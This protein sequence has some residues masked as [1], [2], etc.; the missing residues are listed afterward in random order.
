MASAAR[1]ISRRLMFLAFC[2]CFVAL[3]AAYIG[4]A[5]VESTRMSDAA[6]ETA[7]D[8]APRGDAPAIAP[9]PKDGVRLPSTSA[10]GAAPI[11]VAG[12]PLPSAPAAADRPVVENPAVPG[13]RSGLLFTSAAYDRT[14]GHLAVESAG[15][16][17]TSRQVAALRC[18]RVHF[19]GGAGICLA[20]ERGFFTTYAA[21]TF[22]SDFKI[23]HTIPLPGLPSRARVSPDG[24]RAAMTIFVS[25]DSYNAT[26]FS[27]RTTVVDVA[28][29]KPIADLEE[30]AVTRA[31][32]PFKAIDFNFWGV[33]FARDGNRFFATLRTGSTNYLVEGD[34]DKR[35]AR[36]LRD[37]VECPSVSPD[38]TRIVFKMR[39]T[40]STWR[41]HLLDLATSLDRPL[42]ETRSVD[43]QVEWL[44]ND[45]IAYMLPASA[46]GGASDI[47]T[48]SLNS[49]A[50]PRILVKQG[51]SPAA[52]R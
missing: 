20:A 38:N 10:E 50:P 4:R 18:E 39:V 46:A 36:V 45:S 11:G 17:G 33:T 47:W 31:G 41:L 23:R 7:P 12:P 6:V 2:A 5:R 9:D 3:A 1:P 51:Y 29:G 42:A 26:G 24:R 15:A 8:G 21:H 37:G 40:S 25:G 28:T 16:G 48:L 32:A 49:Q 30:F 14:N 13:T 22:G 44:D 27:T 35:T 19:A 34:V 43:D 52:L